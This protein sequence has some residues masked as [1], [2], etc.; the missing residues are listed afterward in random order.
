MQVVVA[1]M[2]KLLVGISA[3]LKN[4]QPYDGNKLFNLP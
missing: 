1:L 3:M 2:R 4:H